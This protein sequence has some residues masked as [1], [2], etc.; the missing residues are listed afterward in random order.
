MVTP[1]S[2]WS[3]RTVFAPSPGIRVTSIS[4][5]G[6]LAFSLAAAGIS[7]VVTSATIFS[8][9]VAPIPG[10]SL[11]FPA[12]ASSSTETGLWRITRAASL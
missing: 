11:A 7:P 6:N 10:S 5:A 2:S 12:S 9:R 4:E 1:S 8:W 3:L